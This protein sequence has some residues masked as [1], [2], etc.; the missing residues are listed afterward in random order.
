[1]HVQL[2]AKMDSAEAYGSFSTTYY[3]VAPLLFEPQG[4]FLCTGSQEGFLDPP[5][6]ILSVY[7]SRAQLL[8]LT[9]S[10]ETK[11]QFYS[12]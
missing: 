1:M 7:S 12:A 3:G 5:E 4:A 10:F 9:L 2:L 6:I 11:L 8:P